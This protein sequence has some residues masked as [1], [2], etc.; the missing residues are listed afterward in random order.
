LV[1]EA[2]GARII[3]IQ[4]TL[5]DAD[6]ECQRRMRQGRRYLHRSAIASSGPS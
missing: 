2:R 4:G 6:A 5:R 1:V 3:L